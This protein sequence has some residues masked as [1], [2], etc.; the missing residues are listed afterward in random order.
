MRI[1]FVLGSPNVAF[2][3]GDLLVYRLANHLA[4]ANHQVDLIRLCDW[5]RLLRELHFEGKIRTDRKKRSLAEHVYF[6]LVKFGFGRRAIELLGF[7]PSQKAVMPLSDKIRTIYVRRA[8][9]LPVQGYDLAIATSWPT[10]PVVSIALEA[11]RRAYLV[12]NFEDDPLF[13]G[14]WAPAVALTYKL[15]LEII[16]VG[17]ALAKRFGVPSE[18]TLIPGVDNTIF[19]QSRDFSSRPKHSVIIPVRLGPYKGTNVGIQAMRLLRSDFPDLQ[20]SLYGNRHIVSRILPDTTD[21]IRV[22]HNPTSS[23]LVAELNSTRIFLFPSKLEAFPVAPLEAML[24]GCL[25]VSTPNSGVRDYLIDG[26]SGVISDG[27][28]AYSLMK[29]VRHALTTEDSVNIARLGTLQATELDWKQCYLRFDSIL[30]S[31]PP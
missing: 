8:Q 2:V 5:P 7:M 22:V 20:V 13:S 17:S 23:Q 21:W 25:V 4:E 10:A 28:D 27:F 30:E 24:C 14:E 19:K 18:H 9:D 29:S 3:G 12:Q 16:P 1:V 26:R 11:A 15:G 31:A 6:E